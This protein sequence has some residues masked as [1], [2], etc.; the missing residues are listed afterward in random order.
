MKQDQSS[1]FFLYR[2]QGEQNI[3]APTFHQSKWNVPLWYCQWKQTHMSHIRL[4]SHM[5]P[6]VH[7]IPPKMS[8]CGSDMSKCEYICIR[9]SHT[10]KKGARIELFLSRTLQRAFQIPTSP[11]S[12][13]LRAPA[14]TILSTQIKILQ[15]FQGIL[16]YRVL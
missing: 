11:S 5:L 16:L 6:L 1:P 2:Q 8:Q 13:L 10:N 7:Q 14:P 12:H 4:P 3:N 9:F 15:N